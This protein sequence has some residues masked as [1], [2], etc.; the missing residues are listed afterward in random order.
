MIGMF[1]NRSGYTNFFII[2]CRI[3]SWY[4]ILSFVYYENSV[5]GGLCKRGVSLIINLQS[6]QVKK[7]KRKKKKLYV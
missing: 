7:E 3:L 5:R 1:N 4:I 2:L 6:Q